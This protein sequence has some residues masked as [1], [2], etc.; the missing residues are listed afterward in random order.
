MLLSVPWKTSQPCCSSSRAC[1]RWRLPCNS[2]SQ[3][4]LPCWRGLLGQGPP[5]GNWPPKS[6]P[7]TG[8]ALVEG[9]KPMLGQLQ[10]GT[11]QDTWHAEHAWRGCRIRGP[12]EG[13][14]SP[15]YISWHSLPLTRVA[16]D[17]HRL[18]LRYCLWAAS[19]PVVQSA[20]GVCY[21]LL[22]CACWKGAAA[23]PALP[24]RQPVLPV[25]HKTVYAVQEGCAAAG[26]LGWEV[27]AQ[28]LGAALPKLVEDSSALAAA[29]KQ[30]KSIA[31]GC[32]HCKHCRCQSLG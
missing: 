12:L 26:A 23:R 4:L 14:H 28:E 1:I 2:L 22:P 25:S 20:S 8:A 29:I 19:T 24:V 7:S 31:V 6:V 13:Q 21:V 10:V 27:H 11:L 16:Q 17:M 9:F 18:D 15:W 32:M 3:Q 30:V 5:Q